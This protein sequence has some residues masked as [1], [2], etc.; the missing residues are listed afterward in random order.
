MVAEVQINAAAVRM[1]EPGCARIRRLSEDPVLQQAHR[2]RRW[3]PE[4]PGVQAEAS[5]EAPRLRLVASDL[6]GEDTLD[7]EVRQ[8]ASVHDVR[9][10]AVRQ[11]SSGV[12]FKPKTS[13][14]TGVQVFRC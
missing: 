9:V 5:V 11:E 10:G 14:F 7:A 1:M 4:V 8:S 2:D 13:R 12:P 3:R 6:R